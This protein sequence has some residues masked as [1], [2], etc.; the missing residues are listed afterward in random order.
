[1][2]KSNLKLVI[3]FL[4]VLVGYFLGSTIYAMNFGSNNTLMVLCST[5]S[6]LI[7][8]GLYLLF[9]K[10]KHPEIINSMVVEQNDEREKM[11]RE[12]AAHYTLV[13]IF[14]LTFSLA[15]ISIIRQDF[16]ILF[17]S[18]G[19]YISTLLIYLGLIAYFKKSHNY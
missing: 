2:N 1:M 11:I 3:L 5:A 13:F 7:L 14:G 6:A 18:G 10:K 15:G 19:F 8:G 16:I 9:L 17:I 12:K 4:I